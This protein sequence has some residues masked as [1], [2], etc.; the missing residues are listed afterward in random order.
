M[1]A[2]GQHQVE[3]DPY[4]C[5]RLRWEGTVAQV[6]VNNRLGG[7]QRLS[8]QVVIG[9]Q[10]RDP[11]LMGA[12]DAGMGGDTVIHGQDHLRPASMRLIDHL[13]A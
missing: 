10:H 11:Q 2:Q 4:P 1:G 12:I 8:W 9:H 3:R 13:R 7:R 6:R 5:Q